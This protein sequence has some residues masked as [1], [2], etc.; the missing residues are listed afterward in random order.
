MKCQILFPW[1]HKKKKK[2]KKKNIY[3]CLPEQKVS[4]A[5]VEGQITQYIIYYNHFGIGVKI[6]EH[7][8]NRITLSVL[9]LGILQVKI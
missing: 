4:V 5:K 6:N 7:T 9:V 1:K 8:E 2:K 3:S